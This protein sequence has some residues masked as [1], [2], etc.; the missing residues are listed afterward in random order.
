M[1][2]DFIVAGERRLA[3]EPRELVIAGWTG[4][5]RVAVDRH[6]A[7]LETLGIRPP[8]E[9]PCFYQVA[10]SLLTTAESIQL[11]RD[12]STGE[13]ECVLIA[14]WDGLYVGVGSDHTD[15]QVE[16]LDITL[17]KQLCAKPVSR[18]LWS[19]DEVAGHWDSLVMRCWRER[20]GQRELYQEGE[21]G[22][23]LDPLD[24]IERRNGGMTLPQGS[25]MFCGTL[26]ALLPIA[27]GEA[28][29]VELHDPVLERTLSHRYTVEVLEVEA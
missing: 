16:A 12:H 18:Q 11:P 6:I 20:E 26:E 2:L 7:E 10:A 27:P 17:S 3:F 29:C 1:A 21:A 4:R 8:T 23:M 28:F 25:V 19:F 22:S 5:N 24:L 13:V 9:V 15:R 14:A